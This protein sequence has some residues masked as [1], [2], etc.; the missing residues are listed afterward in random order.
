[1]IANLHNLLNKIM[2]KKKL[3]VERIIKMQA[4]RTEKLKQTQG[5][6]WDIGNGIEVHADRYQYILVTPGESDRYYHFDCLAE[7]IND[8]FHKQATKAMLMSEDKGINNVINSLA[9]TQKWL[10]TVITTTLTPSEQKIIRK[11]LDQLN[12]NQ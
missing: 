6:I 10:D 2:K 9:K 12:E 8:L 1:M 5:L 3:S 7:L 4:A 11:S